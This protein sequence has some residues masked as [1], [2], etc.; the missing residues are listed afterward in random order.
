MTPDQILTEFE[1]YEAEFAR[2]YASFKRTRDGIYIG[3]SD[4][5]L[6]RQYVHEIVDLYNDVLGKKFLRCTN[7][8]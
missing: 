4:D 3:Q 5:P 8:T 2:I 6:Y 1:R 7:R